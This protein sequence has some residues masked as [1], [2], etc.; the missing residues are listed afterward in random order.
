MCTCLR[1][2]RLLQLPLTRV[3]LPKEAG[4]ATVSSLSRRENSQ[5]NVP[6]NFRVQPLKGV[7]LF[8]MTIEELQRCLSDLRFTSVEFVKF[9]LQRIH[10][11]RAPFLASS[12]STIL[13]IPMPLLGKP[14]SRSHH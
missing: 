1:M 14:V 7:D 12:I 6:Q 5:Q 13:R 10:S 9:C 2:L 4:A 11:V 3:N 8:E